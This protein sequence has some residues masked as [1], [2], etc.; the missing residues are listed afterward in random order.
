MHRLQGDPTPWWRGAQNRDL[1][2]AQLNPNEW[3]G[4][5]IRFW[6]RGASELLFLDDEQEEQSRNEFREY[7]EATMR[8]LRL[9]MEILSRDVP[10]VFQVRI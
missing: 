2:P 3:C 5:P 1:I 8:S 10:R 9:T 4:Q 6:S 7:T